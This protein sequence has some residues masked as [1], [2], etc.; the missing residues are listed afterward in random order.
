MSHL[1][2]L[3]ELPTSSAAVAARP[4]SVM[5]GLRRIL[6]GLNP[7]SFLVATWLTLGCWHSA[8]VKST[9]TVGPVMIH[10]ITQKGKGYL[11]A[12]SASD[13]M[14]GVGPYDPLTGKQDKK[15][16]VVSNLCWTVGTPVRV[17]TRHLSCV[18]R[19]NQSR[20]SR[21]HAIEVLP[22]TGPAR[23]TQMPPAPQSWPA[24]RSL[25]LA[26]AGHCMHGCEDCQARKSS[27]DKPQPPSSPQSV[28][29]ACVPQSCLCIQE[30]PSQAARCGSLQ[31]SYSCRCPRTPISSL[32]P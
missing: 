27:P 9:E 30:V 24:R 6:P 3:P 19:N 2:V 12:E 1:M 22:L 11:P 10:I 13:K 18:A 20:S 28:A 15:K 21:L 29:V 25:G 4:R 7:S 5:L 26:H 32:M 17:A 14:H 16:P 23:L 31:S 8:E